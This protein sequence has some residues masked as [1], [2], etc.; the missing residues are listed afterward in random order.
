MAHLTLGPGELVERIHLPTA[1][2]GDPSR[3]EKARIRGSIDFP[4][5]GVAIR[6]RKDK[7]NAVEDVAI[8]LTAVNPYPKI[9]SDLRDLIDGNIG[10]DQL[11]FIR[12]TVRKQSK[13]MRT[14]TVAPWYRR[15]VVGAIARRLAAEL[16]A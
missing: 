11:D 10:E 13:P 9:I 7:G 15:R 4:L 14:T 3:Y 8:A 2:A 12:D 16:S 5:A 1:L 6:L